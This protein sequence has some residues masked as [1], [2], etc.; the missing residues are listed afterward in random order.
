MNYARYLKVMNNL[1]KSYKQDFSKFLMGK[2]LVSLLAPIIF[3]VGVLL[4]GCGV[5]YKDM[6]K[7]KNLHSRDKAFIDNMHAKYG[8]QVSYDEAKHYLQSK[9]SGWDYDIAKHYLKK[10]VKDKNSLSIKELIILHEGIRR[11]D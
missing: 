6:F 3:S 4:N 9:L 8:P 11:L 1:H 7:Y 5:P 2:K 10:G